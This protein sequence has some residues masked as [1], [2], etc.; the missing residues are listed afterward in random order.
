MNFDNIQIIAQ[1][2]EKYMTFSF[3]EFRFL[4]SFAFMSSSLDT[5]C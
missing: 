3:G 1:N 5:I 2:F 4:D